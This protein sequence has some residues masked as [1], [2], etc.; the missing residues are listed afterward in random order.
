MTSAS[1]NFDDDYDDYEGF[2]D[3]DE[4]RGISGLVVLLVIL[5]M[6]LAFSFIV[7]LAYNKGVRQGARADIP[8]ITAD[9]EPVKTAANDI[10]ATPASEDR[11]VYD[12]FEGNT[13]PRA[14]VLGAG[15]EQPIIDNGRDTIG[16]LAAAAQ[17]SASNTIEAAAAGAR[18]VTAPIGDAA[19]QAA[20]GV[21]DRVASAGQAASDA[22]NNSTGGY[23]EGA[24]DQLES[25]LRTSVGESDDAIASQ[26]ATSPTP[27]ATTRPTSLTGSST[28]A[29]SSSGVGG[30]HVVQVGAF[31]SEG[32]A[33]V[34]WNRLQD[35]FGGFLDGKGKDIERADLGS[36]GTFYRLRIAGF[37]SKDSAS[38]Y[39]EGLK[40]RNQD[41]LVKAR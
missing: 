23:S 17:D 15:S 41:C 6:L 36:R 28:S 18:N 20:S 10:A 29:V 34:F 8:Q 9:P 5:A 24:V 7:Y 1:D 30:T 26:P 4:D 38:S 22:V 25:V 2:D 27:A 33:D 39:C 37:S 11:E 14:E 21:R 16:N 35:R 31:R 40:A 12:R 19:N 13:A 32:E 3:E